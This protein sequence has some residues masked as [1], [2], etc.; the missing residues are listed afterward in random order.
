MNYFIFLFI[1]IIGFALIE[2]PLFTVIAGLSIICL[3]FID[4]D[5]LSLQIILIEMN[6]L[7]SMPVLVAL[8]L[9][10]FVGCLLTE[11]QAP[12]RIMNFLNATLGWLPGGLAI[13]ALCACT[14]FTA[15][16]GASGVTILALG[17]VLYPILRQKLYD[18]TFTL[19]LLTTSGSLGL[20]FPPSLPIILYGVVSQVNIPDIF[21]AALVP[22]VLLVIVLSLY[23]F[24]YRFFFARSGQR[25]GN[26]ETVIYWGR[27]KQALFEGIW[28][29]PIIAILILGVY[30]GFVTI[31][32][33]SAVILVYVIIVECF[34]LKEVHFTRQLPGIMIESARLS[35]AIIVILG[36][37]LGFTAYLVDEKIPDQI[38]AYLTSLTQNKYV[39]LA[40]LNA[41][42]LAV[43]CVMDIFSAIII[44]VPIIV[45]IALQYGIDPVH[46]GVIFL[47]NLEIGYSTPPVG[48][49]LFISSL[50][51]R[52]PV[53]LL[54]RAS[55]PYLFLLLLLLIL[56]TYIPALSLF[57]LR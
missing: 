23:V 50:K 33:V 42:L 11:T 37:A 18:E 48:I 17:G 5:W 36:F 53:T 51:F 31:A 8:P 12:N 49:N 26:Q 45:P 54:Y 9:F 4:F 10:T 14:F 46:L 47:V 15:M 25:S 16:T 20:L 39:F 21:K 7:A 19:G 38:L 41:F 40:G 32:E 3:Y 55:L 30:G 43:G 22:G 57:M 52:Q 13:A 1:L 44:V 56:I 34:I 24:C 35:G 29:W 2:T 27:I 6:R 28:D